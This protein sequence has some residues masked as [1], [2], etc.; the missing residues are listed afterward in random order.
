MYRGTRFVQRNTFLNGGVQEKR[1]VP[2]LVFAGGIEVGAEALYELGVTAMFSINRTCET[3]DVAR[4]KAK[5]NLC[6]AVEN[7]L[8]LW[9][10]ASAQRAN[11]VAEY[12]K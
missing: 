1:G 5:E 12:R 9:L 3:F 10:A 8:R 2:V 6:S 11:E 4:H 7:M